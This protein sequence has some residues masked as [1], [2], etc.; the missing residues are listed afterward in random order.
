MN[1]MTQTKVT[2][3]F[4]RQEAT[5]LGMIEPKEF[6]DKSSSG[7]PMESQDVRTVIK[8]QQSESKLIRI[9]EG[10]SSKEIA[11]MLKSQNLISSEDEFL[12][13]LYSQGLTNKIRW[14]DYKIEYGL[15]E[16][17]IIDKIV[18]GQFE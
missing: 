3:S 7:K 5:K 2:E 13:K 17:T 1:I 14:G 18:K 12:S 6:F 9:P 15:P 4:I 10:M 16:E 8:L 11:T